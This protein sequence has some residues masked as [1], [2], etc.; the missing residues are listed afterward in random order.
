V[1]ISVF[2]LTVQTHN[3]TNVAVDGLTV[4]GSVLI[5]HTHTHTLS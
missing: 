4:S 3:V 2:E 5:T 1:F